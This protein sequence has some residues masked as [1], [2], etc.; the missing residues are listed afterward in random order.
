MRARHAARGVIAQAKGDANLAAACFDDS[1][2]PA[3][4][5]GEEHNAFLS[6][7]VHLLHGLGLVLPARLI[8][9]VQTGRPA[10]WLVTD[11]IFVPPQAKVDNLKK[12]KFMDKSV[13]R[14]AV[15]ES[16]LATADFQGEK[17]IKRREEEK[18]RE[19]TKMQGGPQ[20]PALSVR[21]EKHMR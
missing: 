20:R 8:P 18:T 2:N 12:K 11:Y 13:V 17:I 19:L 7:K 10:L 9:R 6:D 16:E 1:A 15:F 3:L 14:A 4:H 21:P 5:M